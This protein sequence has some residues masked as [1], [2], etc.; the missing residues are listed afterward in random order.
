M[1]GLRFVIAF[2]SDVDEMKR[3]YQEGIGLRPAMDSPAFVPFENDGGASLSLHCGAA[4]SAPR[5]RAVLRH[6][7]RIETDVDAL[8]GHGIE[9]VTEIRDQEF[10][11]TVHFRDP[12]GNLISLLESKRPTAAAP[13]GRRRRARGR[14][15]GGHGRRAEARLGDRAV[16]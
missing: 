3:F 10:G 12:D 4:G 16:A 1:R 9:F 13:R 15:R 14:N 11:R 6:R 5:D 8:R 7:R 2:T